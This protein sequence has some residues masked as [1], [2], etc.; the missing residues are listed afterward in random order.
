M[1]NVYEPAT[2]QY[3]HSEWKHYEGALKPYKPRVGPRDAAPFIIDSKVIVGQWGMI[4]PLQPERVA[5][6]VAGV[7]MTNNART[8]SP[9]VSSENHLSVNAWLL[10]NTNRLTRR[11]TS[12]D[13]W[14]R[15]KAT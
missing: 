6:A 11:L 12:L 14:F 3:L 4:R 8:E 5:K 13:G 15:S 2:E 9:S 1:C 7:L 10:L